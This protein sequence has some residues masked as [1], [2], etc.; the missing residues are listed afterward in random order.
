M[1]S[2]AAPNVRSG[3]T[4]PRGQTLID[5]FRSVGRAGAASATFHLEEGPATTSAATLV[6]QAETMAGTLTSLGVRRG[7]RVGIV[8]RNRPEWLRSALACWAA[9]ATVVPLPFHLRIRDHAGFAQG[10]ERLVRAAAC[11]VVLS[12]DRFLADL[13]ADVAVAWEPATSA[14]MG[15]S[16]SLEGHGSD[17]G[18]LAPD[19]SPEDLAVVQFTSG[20]T[21]EPKGACL[22]HASVLAAVSG[23]AAVLGARPGVDRFV[24]WLPFFHDWGLFGFALR[25]LMLGCDVH[26]LPTERFAA[27]PERWFRVVTDVRGTMTAGPPSSV[28]AALRSIGDAEHAGSLDLSSIRWFHL[29]AERTDPD[30]VDEIAE[31]AGRIGLR[32]DAIG[33]SYGMA[34]A[35]LG[36]TGARPGTGQRFD[37]VDPDALARG[38]AEPPSAGR[39]RRVTSCGPPL[40]SVELRIAEG[41]VA[42]PERHVGEIQA[43]G[44]SIMRGYLVGGPEPVEQ[45]FDDGWLRTGDLGYL[46]DGELFVVGRRKDLII[47]QGRNVAPEDAEGAAARVEGVR[48]GRVVAFAPPD[49]P[50]GTLIV[51]L[52]ATPDADLASLPA[53]VRHAVT[54]AVEVIP[55]EVLVLHEGE[56]PKTTSGKLRRSEVRERHRRGELDVEPAR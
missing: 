19:R 8:G 18:S 21:A 25:P 26:V 24:S 45:P 22:T 48:A 29:G 39:A 37:R 3:T 33:T 13:P 56:I 42:L 14:G 43:R 4:R 9:G 27:S 44:P 38:I 16:A 47:A 32:P 1:T 20:S 40:P 41:G 30:A 36:L 12:E 34:E 53:R 2:G 55:A 54:E 17:G 50:E 7:D 28:L 46:A 15:T 31:R 51:A 35:T 5:V 52:E 49:A 11:R 10:L 6:H 23:Y